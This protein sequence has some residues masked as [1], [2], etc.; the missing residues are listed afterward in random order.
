MKAVNY[1]LLGIL[2]FVAAS[3]CELLEDAADQTVAQR[4]E[5]RWDVDE[6]T[7][8]FKSTKDAYYVYIDISEVDDNTIAIDGFLDIDA[9]SVYATISGTTLN[10]A[11]QELDGWSVYGSGLI[12]PNFKKITWE[13]FVDE[14]SGT[15]HPVTAV[16]TK[17]DY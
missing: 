8:D 17:S 15:W 2:L 3:S 12:S 10:L 1:S 11:E 7:I 16:Y 6:S 5:G 13:Y 14:G 9:G 4:L